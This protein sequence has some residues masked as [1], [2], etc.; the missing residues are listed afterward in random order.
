MIAGDADRVGRMTAAPDPTPL[1]H[2]RD[3]IYAADLAVAAVTELDLF[4]ALGDRCLT[5]AEVAAALGLAERPVAAMCDVLESLGLVERDGV[6]VAASP[7]ARAYLAAGSP[8]DLRPYFASLA[9]RP[10]VR[11]LAG[12]LR[13]GAPAAW[14]SSAGGED[15]AARL[16]DPGFAERFTA[17]MDARGRVL[18]PALAEALADLPV[19]RV[20]DVAGG[21]GVYACGLLDARPEFAASVLERPPVDR[22]ARTLL[23]RRGYERVAVIAGDMFSRL[24]G[25]HDLHLFAHVLHDWDVPAVDSLMRASFA[26]LPPGG[27]IVD[28]DV[29]VGDG[30]GPAAAYSAL[31]MH[32][33][34]GRC[35]AV[36]EIAGLMRGAGFADVHV[37]PTIGDRSAVCARRP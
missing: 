20:L 12:V 6:T 7:L 16:D 15:W 10:A 37:H 24:P 29:H 14:A 32:A 8:A 27:W 36:S 30:N 28:Y 4:T 26:A 13:T 25:G 11:E 23:D 22:A 19:R 1:L 17:A 3:G 35:Y 33:T 21:S 5:P 9:E 34:E 31:L 2:L 18:A